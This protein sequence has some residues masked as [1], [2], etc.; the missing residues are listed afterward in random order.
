M[1]AGAE[2]MGVK[3]GLSASPLALASPIFSLISHGGAQIAREQKKNPMFRNVNSFWWP[4][5]LCS[6][7]HLGWMGVKYGPE[8]DL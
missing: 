5:G 8:G 7:W 4:A 1:I 3:M 6:N 2:Q